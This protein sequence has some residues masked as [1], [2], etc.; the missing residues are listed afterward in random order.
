MAI[1]NYAKDGGQGWSDLHVVSSRS[2]ASQ[3]FVFDK[4]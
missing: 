1:D 4:I 3:T 2:F